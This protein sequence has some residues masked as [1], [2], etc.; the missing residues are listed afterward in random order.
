VPPQRNVPPQGNVPPQKR[1]PPQG[2]VPPQ[3]SAP[4]Q[5]NVPPKKSGF[6]PLFLI[7]GIGAALIVVFNAGLVLLFGLA[8]ASSTGSIEDETGTA[9]AVTEKEP[10]ESYEDDLKDVQE[11]TAAKEDTGEVSDAG[12]EETKDGTTYKGFGVCFDGVYVDLDD[13]DIDS[14]Y[15]TLKDDGTGYLYMGEDNQGEITKWSG[16]GDDFKVK[17]KDAGVSDKGYMRDGIL[18]KEIEGFEIAFRTDDYDPDS[19]F[20]LS[21]EEW[22]RINGNESLEGRSERPDTKGVSDPGRLYDYLTQDEQA[23][24]DMLLRVCETGETPSA[25]I[26]YAR[27]PDESVQ[28]AGSALVND[29][30][31]IGYGE[32][33]EENRS[34]E[35]FDSGAEVYRVNSVRDFKKDEAEV[36]AVIEEFVPT[37]TGSIEDKVRQINDFIGERTE[38]RE[39]KNIDYTPYGALIEGK[40]C[41]QGYSTAFKAL[42][43]AAGIKSYAIFG[44]GETPGGEM[45]PHAWNIVQLDDGNWYEIDVLWNDELQSDEYFCVPTS[46]M[47]KNHKREA[48]MFDLYEVMPKTEE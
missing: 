30:P 35:K 34:A 17:V 7:L 33:Y 36:R 12:K 37:L 13:Q 47:I 24:Y 25:T 39:K 43:D 27:L 3:R 28:M 15:I 42:C 2:N 4:L 44:I 45:G 19:I 10:A 14:W 1:V 23:Y 41:C 16:S 46:K 31:Y 18:R 21:E 11:D 22:T 29:V 38:F 32:A 48:V 26:C 20:L 40:A 9:A 6:K 8:G 5:G